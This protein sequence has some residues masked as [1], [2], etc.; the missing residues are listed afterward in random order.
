MKLALALLAVSACSKHGDEP[1]RAKAQVLYDEIELPNI[2]PGES[3][4]TLDDRGH[5]WAIAERDRVITE[6]ELGTPPKITPHPLV[7][8]PAGLDTEALTWLGGGK[9]AIGT[10]GQQEPTASVLYAELGSDGQITVVRAR[11]LTPAELGVTLTKNH[12]AEGICGNGDDVLVA[13]ETV[14]KLPDGTRWAPLVRIGGDA[15]TMQRFRLTTDGG[16][17]SALSCTFAADGSVDILAIERHYGVSRILHAVARP[18]TSDI[19]PTVEL[20]LFP[21]NKDR[22]NLEGIVRL[23]DGRWVAINDNQGSHVDGP[24]ELLVFHPR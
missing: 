9:F 1:D 13:I 20:D 14:G 12:G 10:E 15:S 4:L 24:T 18:N 16:K 21:V 6:I 23:A 5:L 17:L 8:V 7:G 19:T 11:E 3:D 22:F 2:A